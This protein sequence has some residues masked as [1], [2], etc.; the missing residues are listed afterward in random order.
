MQRVGTALDA[1][2]FLLAIAAVFVAK[3]MGYD[4]IEALKI[5]AVSKIIYF[6]FNLLIIS[7]KVEKFV[8]RERRVRI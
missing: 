1:L 5:F 3:E 7:W 8:R 6:I 4:S 2:H